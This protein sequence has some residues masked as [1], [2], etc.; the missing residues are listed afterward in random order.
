MDAVYRIIEHDIG[1]GSSVLV[2]SPDGRDDFLSKMKA[3]R[4]DRSRYR[5]IVRA[6]SRL[7]QRGEAPFRETMVRV[8]DS[9]LSLIEIKVPGQVIRIMAYRGEKLVL[10]FDFDGHQGSGKIATKD[11]ERGRMLAK[12][13]KS[14]LE[15]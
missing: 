10:L 14:A 2:L 3:R 13:A 15:D 12:H 6:V 9:E 7:V 5:L 8:L 1:G 4:G 11:L